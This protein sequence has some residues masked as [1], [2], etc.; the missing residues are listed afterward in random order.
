MSDSETTIESL[1]GRRLPWLAQVKLRRAKER[2][3]TGL[4]L[5]AIIRTPSRSMS[6]KAPIVAISKGQSTVPFKPALEA[7]EVG[8]V[9]AGDS[10]S[11]VLG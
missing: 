2:H 1:T 3:E 10:S 6:R 5:S 9:R 4:L 7:S 11:K 8:E